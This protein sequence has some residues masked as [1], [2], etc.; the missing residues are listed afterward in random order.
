MAVAASALVLLLAALVFMA[1][2][3]VADP[4]GWMD[5]LRRVVP[6][7]EFA[8]PRDPSGLISDAGL[9]LGMGVGLALTQ[10]SARFDAG[11]ALWKRA[12]RYLIGLI[13]VLIFWRGLTLV[14]PGGMDGLGMMLR[15]VRY[16]LTGLW[17]AYLA[18]L[19]F[20]KLKLAERAA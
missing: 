14:F 12:L 16:A 19:V 4:P 7:D 5:A 2:N 11:G 18:P 15:Y 1:I 20:L 8:M 17:A 3:T 9:V 10:R 13:G 6:P